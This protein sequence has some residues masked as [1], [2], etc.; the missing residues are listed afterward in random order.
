[1]KLIS[2]TIL[3]FCISLAA[4]AANINMIAE[5]VKRGNEFYEQE[6]YKDAQQEYTAAQID[7]PGNSDINYNQANVFYKQKKYDKAVASYKK[8][9]EMA[10]EKIEMKCYYNI[11][12]C[13]V[14]Q[15]KLKEALESYKR[16]LRLDRDDK[17]VKYNIE[18]VQLKLKEIESKKKKDKKK[19]DDP[20]N[21]LLKELEKLIGVQAQNNVQTKKLIETLSFGITNQPEF[22]GSLT[23]IFTNE[24]NYVQKTF[25]IREGFRDLRTNLPPE[26]L[27]GKQSPQAQQGMPNSQ[28]KQSQPGQNQFSLDQSTRELIGIYKLLAE[29]A[30]SL[31]STNTTTAA[32]I[33]KLS[34]IEGKLKQAGNATKDA[35]NKQ[36]S[37]SGEDIIK[38][39]KY[40]LVSPKKSDQSE[41]KKISEEFNS[42]M[43]NIQS[44]LNSQ[45]PSQISGMPGVTNGAQKTLAQKIDNAVKF[46]ATA[47]SELK[48]SAEYL[49]DSWTNAPPSQEVGLR[50]L[51]KA[52]KEFDDKNQKNQKKNN[53]QNNKQKN[54]KKKDN[55]DD[56]K[57][58]NKNKDQKKDKNKDKQK[59]DKK[60]DKKQNKNQDKQKQDKQQGKPQ[61]KQN[62]KQEKQPKLDKKQVKQMLKNFKEDQRNKRKMRMQKAHAAGYIPVDK[63]W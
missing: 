36:F 45:M 47:H 4:S 27:Y 49:E 46:L 20:L 52:R 60:K 29:S 42:L 12:D 38:R 44:K 33:N 53:K 35:A 61:D 63:D 14:Q 30:S 15:G 51:I 21:K 8:A 10:T 23:D 18:Y 56:K 22:T 50:Y 39:I 40:M 62:K 1:M 6:N 31:S 17:D 13:L 16:A 9:L 7:A 57:K 58:Q 41:F 24:Q 34:E 2:L 59:Q 19:K 37:A 55:K 11:G 25:E 43:S 26:K 3:T 32:T 48:L 54:K 28:V 5:K